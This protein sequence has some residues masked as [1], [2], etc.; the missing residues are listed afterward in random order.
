[1]KHRWTVGAG[2]SLGTGSLVC[3]RLWHLRSP[4][5][6]ARAYECLCVGWTQHL[7]Q[8]PL[9]YSTC[10]ALHLLP[11]VFFFLSVFGFVFEVQLIYHTLSPVTLLIYLL[12]LESCNPHYYLRST[13]FLTH[14]G[15]SVPPT[16]ASHSLC[17]LLVLFLFLCLPTL[18]I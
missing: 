9:W 13:A 5:L 8:P 11:F 7:L 12:F 14:T 2:T 18:D 1:M 17:H 15:N 16:V 4:V 3:S 10:V 6:L